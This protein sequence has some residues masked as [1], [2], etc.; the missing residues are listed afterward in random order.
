MSAPA[1]RLADFLRRLSPL[2]KGVLASVLLHGGLWL[3]FSWSHSVD[4]ADEAVSALELDLTRPFRIT[5]DPSKAHRAL[6]PGAGAPVVQTPT[7]EAGKG[8]IGGAEDATPD[9]KGPA[10]DWVL[11]TEQTKVLETPATGEAAG[12]PDGA[13]EGAGL[14]GL[15]GVGDGEVDWVYLTTLP[16]L[17]NRERLMRDIQ[18]FYPPEERAAGQEGWVVLDV[19]IDGD[20]RV[21]RVGVSDATAKSFEEAARRVLSQARFSPAKAGDKRVPVKI[22]WTIE[23]K[24][25][26]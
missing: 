19:H 5:D 2:E 18:R 17:L 22:P 12:R 11:P 15:G 26:E 25:D 6:N 14:G 10:K 16:R 1:E 7:L 9:A 24:L 21:V 20:G 3:C 8:L 4:I 23:F 13:G